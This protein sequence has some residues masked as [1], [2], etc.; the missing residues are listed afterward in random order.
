MSNGHQPSWVAT[1]F[2]IVFSIFPPSCTQHPLVEYHKGDTMGTFYTLQYWIQNGVRTQ[3]IATEIESLLEEFERQLS[4]WQKDSWISQFNA[5]SSSQSIP[6]PDYAA[7]VLELCLELAK[8]SDGAFDPTISPLIELWG[9]G[10]ERGTAIPKNQAIQNALKL[11]GYQKLVFDRENQTLLKRQDEIQLNCSAVAKGYAVD[12]IAQLLEQKGIENFLIN[13]GGEITARG[14]KR[15][16]EAWQVG[17]SQPQGD[18]KQ[19]K[20]EISLS[21][22]NQSLATSGHSQRSFVLEG[23]RYSHILNAKTGFPVQTETASATIIAPTCALADGLAT[24]ALILDEAQMD[25]IAEQYEG[26]VI[27]RNPWSVQ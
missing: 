18:G 2:V 23:K 5:A 22:H 8:Y 19:V 6:V 3:E 27:Y 1:A 14:T 15:N 11:T 12:L 4:N 9:F 26:V 21:L 10:T 25:R 16:G 24:L 17:I 7:P 13:I 20:P